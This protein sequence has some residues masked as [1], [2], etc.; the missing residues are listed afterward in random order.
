[1]TTLAA[2]VALRGTGW[3][4]GEARLVGVQDALAADD[5][6]PFTLEVRPAPTFALLTRQPAAQRPS[7]S[8]YL[9]LALAPAARAGKVVRLD[10]G[11]L[12]PEALAGSEVVVLDHPGK[13]AGETV[14][15]L[16]ALLRR[17]RGVLYVAAAPD[18]AVNL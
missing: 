10:P 5:V 15:Q 14:K 6:R 7:S 3:Q 1:K 13:L 16:A 4:T 2:E 9:E 11:Q 12:D 17:G 18:D 8:Y